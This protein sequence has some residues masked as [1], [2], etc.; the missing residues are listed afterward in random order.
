MKKEY[1]YFGVIAAV[2]IY[3]ITKLRAPVPGVVSS[4]V[5]V[6][7][8]GTGTA[9][10]SRDPARVSAFSALASIAQGQT[11]AETRAGELAAG[12]EAE[13][14]RTSAQSEGLLAQLGFA[15]EQLG[16]SRELGLG[17]QANQ[18]ELGLAGIQ[19]GLQQR[20]LD[21][22]TQLAALELMGQ[23]AQNRTL[24]SGVLG[25]IAAALG[26]LRPRTTGASGGGGASG[27]QTNPNRQRPRPGEPTVPKIGVF[28]PPFI[29][30]WPE[31]RL[32]DPWDWNTP[33]GTFDP[34]GQGFGGMSDWLPDIFANTPV[35]R[36]DSSLVI[37]DDEGNVLN[38]LPG[39]E[40]TWWDWFDPNTGWY[41]AEP[42]PGGY[43]GPYI[44]GGESGG[45][46]DYWAGG[47][48]GDFYSDYDYGWYG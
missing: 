21:A 33:Y 29:P 32:P 9:Y 12:L 24:T 38:L 22:D 1:I 40:D 19:A 26:A 31:P 39:S 42:P 27:N 18:R 45:G 11:Q 8:G 30:G 2:A 14:I 17:A 46:Y 3:L 44:G 36:E 13:R 25:A 15:R 20:Q 48:G 28:N 47:S 23:Q 5:P 10:D 43:G 37:K 4:L 41:Y 34:S 7:I 6:S 16:V 35:L